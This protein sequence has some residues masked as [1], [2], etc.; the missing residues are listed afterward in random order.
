MKRKYKPPI[1]GIYRAPHKKI[2]LSSTYGPFDSTDH[3]LGHKTKS[4]NFS[5]LKECRVC[6][7]IMWKKIRNQQQENVWE[8]HK[9]VEIEQHISKQ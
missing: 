8:T 1:T 6:S 7:E 9:Y 4:V 5:G 2:I 3:M